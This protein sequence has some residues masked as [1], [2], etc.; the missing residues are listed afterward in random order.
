MTEQAPTGLSVLEKERARL[1]S[2]RSRLERQEEVLNREELFGKY[3]EGVTPAEGELTYQDYLDQRPAQGVIRDG[4]GFRD[5][6]SGAF[7]KKELYEAQQGTIQDHYDQVGGLVNTGEYQP[8][9]YDDMGVVQLA[10][11]ASKARALGD[12]AG[13]EDVRA[14]VEHHLTMDAMKDDSESPEQAQARYEAELARY[15]SL[16]E[17]FEN[18]RNATTPAETFTAPVVD[19]A[20]EQ[21]EEPAYEVVETD[22]TLPTNIPGNEFVMLGS[23]DVEDAAHVPVEATPSEETPADSNGEGESDVA[24]IAEGKELVVVENEVVDEADL[25]K[26]KEVTIFDGEVTEPSRVERVKSW[27][28]RERKS[29]QEY[30]GMAYWGERW[31][32]AAK[33]LRDHTLDYGVT[34]ETSNEDREQKR[35]RNRVVILAGVA[36]LG[37]V[38][39]TAISLGIHDGSGV[40]A[41]TS[42]AGLD[43]VPSVAEVPAVDTTPLSPVEVLPLEVGDG[44][45]GAESI[46][47]LPE[48]PVESFNISAGQGGEALFTN[49]GIDPSKWYANEN[50]L[51]SQFPTEFYRLSDGHVGIANSGMLSQGAQ[52]YIATLK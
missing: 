49:L 24:T 52:D 7:A 5:A 40:E 14:A 17:R 4:E 43:Q 11:E 33:G 37:V 45:L 22:P 31:N 34:E 46:P 30:G 21:P 35:K 29:Y 2:E 20:E 10:K 25:A 36:A 42:G 50:T 18:L 19:A 28:K 12:R 51:L 47:H 16:V 6:Q 41:T 39:A 23:P 9:N 38:A 13:E 27:F 1:A 32:R 8:P 15:D 3:D 48:L 44:A 26:G